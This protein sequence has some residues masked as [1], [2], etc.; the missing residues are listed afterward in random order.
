MRK[1][2]SN[3][4][5]LDSASGKRMLRRLQSSLAAEVYLV[6]G[7][8]LVYLVPGKRMLRR[9]QSSLAAEVYLLRGGRGLL[10]KRQRFS[11]TSPGK[12]MLRR[13]QSSLVAE[14]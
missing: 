10:S 8:G 1:P 13:L 2:A 6:R 7:R 14:V 4:R 3:I 9:L 11:L 5:E 12:R